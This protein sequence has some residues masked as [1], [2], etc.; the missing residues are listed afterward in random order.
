MI[1]INDEQFEFLLQLCLAYIAIEKVFVE[2]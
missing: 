1:G 2:E